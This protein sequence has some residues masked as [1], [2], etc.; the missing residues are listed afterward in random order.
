MRTPTL[1]S[2]GIKVQFFNLLQRCRYFF[3][4][5]NG[6][7][8][9]PKR[10]SLPCGHQRAAQS[11]MNIDKT[12]RRVAQFCCTPGAR[13]FTYLASGMSIA[14]EIGDELVTDRGTNEHLDAA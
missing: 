3:Q 9:P 14:D 7:D 10:S 6:A 12:N 8:I 13:A 5:T 1:P 4:R 11:G 2:N